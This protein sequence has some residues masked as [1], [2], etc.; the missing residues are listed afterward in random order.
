MNKDTTE[1]ATFRKWRWFSFG[2]L[3]SSVFY[4]LLATNPDRVATNIANWWG[5]IDGTR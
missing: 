4:L 5:I 2:W 1:T 3:S